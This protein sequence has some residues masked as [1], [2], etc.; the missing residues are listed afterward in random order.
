[1]LA[2]V[3]ATA[4]GKSALADALAAELG[5][6]IVSADSMQVYRGMNIGTAKTPSAE[7]NVPY[8]CLDLVE[9]GEPFT[10]ALYQRA[11][12]SAIDDIQ[13][14]GRLPV[15][16]GGSGLYVRVALDDF[17]F[18]QRSEEGVSA[19]TT[20]ALRQQLQ[21]QA[22]ALGA[23]EFHRLLAERD[24]AS[25][26]LIHPHNVRRV[27]RAFELLQQGSSYAEQ[28]ASFCEYR[29]FYP[30]RY[31]GIAVEP[32]LLYRAIEARVDRMLEQGLLDEVRG[33]LQRGLREAL[34]AAQA[35][36]Y[37]ELVAHLEGQIT[38][39]EA[40]AQ[41]KQATRRF[42]KRQRSWFKRDPRICWIEA[43]DLHEQ[44]LDGHLDASGLTCALYERALKL[45]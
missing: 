25:A 8:H 10:A 20:T 22:D 30:S 1:V 29:A 23:L 44:A 17:C 41:I 36:G 5:G 16:C 4:T 42:A 43:S 9:P 11:A 3:G 34:T 13:A 18:D 14:R 2:V 32:A 15:L 27:V 38:L 31:L 26:A 37:K 33:L 35:I 39:E 21:A 12:R 7:R 24:P 6:E 19:P 40:S 45:L 28:S